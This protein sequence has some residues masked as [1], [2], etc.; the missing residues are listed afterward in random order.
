MIKLRLYVIKETYC[1]TIINA[2]DLL[3]TIYFLFPEKWICD[4]R[5]LG[6][7]CL[8][9]WRVLL[10]LPCNAESRDIK[11]SSLCRLKLLRC[12][13]NPITTYPM[14]VSLPLWSLFREGNGR[15]S[16]NLLFC[17]GGGLPA[18]QISPYESVRN[19]TKCSFSGH[20]GC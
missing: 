8:C 1:D 14:S 13:R 11:S 12:K 18:V 3:V 6:M 15:M 20:F 10:P 16:L 9:D 2:L 4:N 17:L 7:L 19:G 5:L